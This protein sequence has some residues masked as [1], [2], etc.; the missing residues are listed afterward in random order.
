MPECTPEIYAPGWPAAPLLAR[1]HEQERCEGCGLWHIW[2]PLPAGSL[3]ECW[4]CN[5]RNVDPATLGEDD[6]V[7]D[8]PLCLGCQAKRDAQ[9]EADRRAWIAWGAQRRWA[10]AT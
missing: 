8:E 10:D 7:P 2:T 9:I 1:T 3:I 6:G 5:E 4:L